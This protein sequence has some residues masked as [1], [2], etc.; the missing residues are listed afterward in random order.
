VSGGSHERG[1]RIV[2]RIPEKA[3]QARNLTDHRPDCTL[4]PL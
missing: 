2:W 4:G 3:K 1:R